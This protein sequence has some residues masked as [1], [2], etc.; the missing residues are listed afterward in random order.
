MPVERAQ[1]LQKARFED[2]RKAIRIR[3]SQARLK[4]RESI[5]AALGH[6]LDSGHWYKHSCGY[7]YAIGN[8]GMAMVETKCPE[9]QG[10]I[11]GSHH[12]SAAR[13]ERLT[14]NE[15]AKQ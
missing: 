3:S 13:N 1:V 12:Q 5:A 10:T 4:E 9:C 15:W 7:I 11:G 14:D 6:S 2:L 8:C